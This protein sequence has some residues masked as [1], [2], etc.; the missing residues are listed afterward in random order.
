MTHYII[1]KTTTGTTTIKTA[2]ISAVVITQNS[3]FFEIHMESGT[4]FRTMD[5]F[6]ILKDWLAKVNKGATA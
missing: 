5:E 4:I 6:G 3:N 1:V 2:H